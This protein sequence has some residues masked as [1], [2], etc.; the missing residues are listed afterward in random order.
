M[1]QLQLSRTLGTLRIKETIRNIFKYRVL[2]LKQSH[3]QVQ[4]GI[5]LTEQ[6]HCQKEPPSYDECQTE[7]WPKACLP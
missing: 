3:S 4:A 7:Y 2:Q 5:W 1:S 6:G